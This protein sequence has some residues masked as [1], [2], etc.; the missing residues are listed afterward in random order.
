MLYG[1]QSM[2]NGKIVVGIDFDGTL[3]NTVD[4]MLDGRF[5]G[6]SRIEK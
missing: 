2:R 6:K 4:A 5:Y 1:L 3:A